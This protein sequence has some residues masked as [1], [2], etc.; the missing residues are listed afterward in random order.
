MTVTKPS[1]LLPESI[2]VLIVG[3]GPVGLS[4]AI[5]LRL[6]GVEVAVIEKDL[7]IVEGHPKGRSNDL[8]TVEHY[9]RWG[10]S[11]KLRKLSWQPANS[12]QRL[13]ITES[14]IQKPLGSFPLFYGRDAE[15]SNDLAAEPSFSVPQPITMRFLQARALELGASVFRGWKLISVRQD[16]D[17]VI[18]EIQSPDDKVYSITSAY[19]VG[20][21]GPGSLVRKS[22]GIQQKG[23][24][25]IGRTLSFM[26]QAEGHRISDLISSPAHD[27]LG[28][29]F[30]LSPRISS[31]ISIPGKDDWGYSITVPDGKVL[32]EEEILSVGQEILG[33]KAN[34]RILSQSSY[35][36]FTRVSELYQKGRLL[37]AGDASH[38]CPPTGGH[39]MNVGIGDAVNLGWKIAAVL[40]GWGGQKL[41]E[42]YDIE[43]RPVGERVSDAAMKNSYDLKKVAEIFERLSSLEDASE[44]ERLRRGQLV[45]D[46]TY[47]EWNIVGVALDQRYDTSPV[48]VRDNHP[49]APYDGTKIWPHATP[50]HRAPH[51]WLP[52]GS[53]LLDHLGEEFTLLDVEAAEENVQEILAAADRAGLPLKRLQLSAVVARTKYAAEIT[54]IRPDQYISWQGSQTND[55]ELLVDIIRGG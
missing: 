37:I 31:I 10:V 38:L 11:D 12:K 27:A 41:L 40:K 53:P 29:L 50:G 35:K 13:V 24:E 48:I 8:R 51:V 39:N 45:Y 6:H 19:T 18:A 15:E 14:L 5:E 36:V 7:E 26:V 4:L 54:I 42:S 21:D 16:E 25:P 17:R 32:T 22:A 44:E 52:D 55:P 23:V 33:V 43:R 28:M 34:L 9:R 3:A 2:P 46:L 49:S 47:P 1:E 20:C 30:V